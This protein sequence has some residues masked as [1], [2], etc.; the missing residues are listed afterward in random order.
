MCKLEAAIRKVMAFRNVEFDTAR[1]IVVRSLGDRE[2]DRVGGIDEMAGDGGSEFPALIRKE[3]REIWENKEIPIQGELERIRRGREE[4]G[5]GRGPNR[6]NASY[7]EVAR[8]DFEGKSKEGRMIPA[9]MEEGRNEEEEGA[10]GWTQVKNGGRPACYNS[11]TDLVLTN[12]RYICLDCKDKVE[13]AKEKQVDRHKTLERIP[14]PHE[15]AGEGSSSPKEQ[16]NLEKLAKEQEKERRREIR[17]EEERKKRMEERKKKEE[18]RLIDELIAF[19]REKNIEGRVAQAIQEGRQ[20]VQEKD[21]IEEEEDWKA[22]VTP[23]FLYYVDEKTSQRV[24]RKASR[25]HE[26]ALERRRREGNPEGW[27]LWDEKARKDREKAERI[28]REFKARREEGTPTA[29]ND[30]KGAGRSNIGGLE[31]EDEGA[32]VNSQK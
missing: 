2:P 14:F 24:R 13:R 27:I 9:G 28:M 21:T 26:K 15:M 8:K 22:V 5:R 18:E 20:R 10:E 31:K 11:R 29:G 4:V 30:P 17:Q 16:G 19:L 25:E 23:P 1:G 3:R 12:N 6:P 32:R 7:S